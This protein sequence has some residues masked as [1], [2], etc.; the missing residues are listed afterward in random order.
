MQNLEQLRGIHASQWAPEIKPGNG[1][2][3]AST[4]AK[5]VPALIIQDGFLGAL[6]FA[7]DDH[8]GL[9]S[10]FKGI[11]DHLQKTNYLQRY[12]L[13]HTDPKV[14]FQDLCGKSPDVLRAITAEAMAYLNYLRRF[15]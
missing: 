6:A 4:V 10:V 9:C 2:G 11:I 1:E 3:K 8:P 15:A 14:F 12:G 13:N 7:L 5:K